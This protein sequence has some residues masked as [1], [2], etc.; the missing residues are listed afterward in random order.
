MACVPAF[1]VVTIGRKRVGHRIIKKLCVRPPARVREFF[2][3]FSMKETDLRAR[4]SY[5]CRSWESSCLISS[6]PGLR[7]MLAV[8]MSQ[9]EDSSWHRTLSAS[10]IKRDPRFYQLKPRTL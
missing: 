8:N 1:G 2:V 4:C 3:S 9:F 6:R 7:D 5:D 10:G